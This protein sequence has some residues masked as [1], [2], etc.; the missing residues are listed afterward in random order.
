[1]PNIKRYICM[2]KDCTKSVYNSLP[3]EWILHLMLIWLTANTVFWLNMFPHSNGILDTLSPRYLTTG[4]HLDYH[5]HVYLEFS[6][7]VQTHESHTNDKQPQ[8]I[9]AICL[10]QWAM[11][12]EVTTSC[13]WQ[14]DTIS[15]IID[16]WSCPFIIDGWSCPCQMMQS[17]ALVNWDIDRRCQKL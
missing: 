2:V 4:K 10:A 7:Y 8:T 12:R 1:M 9:G 16:G 3:F 17:H 5:K 13:H 6:S 14:L 11:N 15:F